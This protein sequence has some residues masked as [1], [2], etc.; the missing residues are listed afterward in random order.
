VRFY[1]L[2]SD[3]SRFDNVKM[4]ST[5]KYN[6]GQRDAS[7]PEIEFRAHARRLD[8]GQLLAGSTDTEAEGPRTDADVPGR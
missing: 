8:A 4:D 3:P 7:D 2:D 5:L 1:T 6:P